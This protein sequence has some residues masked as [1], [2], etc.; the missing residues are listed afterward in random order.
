MNT[1]TIKN[2]AFFVA[3]L[4]MLF[5]CSH[6]KDIPYFQNSELFESSKDVKLYDMTIKP[7]DQLTI[8]VFSPTDK[9]AVGI[10]NIRDPR[11]L[12]S[13]LQ[14]LSSSGSHLHDY[15]VDDE[16]NIDFPIIGKVRLGGLTINEAN[17]HIEKLIRPYFQKDAN[18]VVNTRIE[19]FEVS[20]LG[21]V[22]NPNTFTL[23]R[24]RVNVLEAL[25]MAG[26]MTIH[27][28]R[29]NVKVLREL[30]DG[31]Y[32]VHELDMRDANILNS[33]YY[34]LH[35]RDIVYVE[36][37]EVIA[38]DAKIGRTTRLWARGISIT[39]SIGS[40]LYRVLQ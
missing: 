12:E 6:Y 37:N 19:N 27:G 17:S 30:A 38:Q 31:T 39:I 2:Y 14:R 11:T 4:S 33:P 32:E 7:K 29:N 21:E 36:P 24:P 15:V 25:A 13:P 10:F 23:S 28:K 9:E 16:G 26:D 8:S 22:K 40:L 35:Q 3:M 34:Y 20:V 5:S 18:Y 1:N